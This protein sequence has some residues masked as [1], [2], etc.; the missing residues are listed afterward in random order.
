VNTSSES[1]IGPHALI[2]VW[3]A[4]RTFRPVLILFVVARIIGARSIAGAKRAARKEAR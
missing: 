1:A 3:D 2:R 4:T